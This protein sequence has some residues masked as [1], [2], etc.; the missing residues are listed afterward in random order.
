MNHRQPGEMLDA[1]E[2][3]SQRVSVAGVTTLG[4]EGHLCDVALV[5]S[6]RW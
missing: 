3:E 4:L 6:N 5:D 2:P 1:A